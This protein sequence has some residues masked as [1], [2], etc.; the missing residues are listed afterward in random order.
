MKYPLESRPNELV[1]PVREASSHRDNWFSRY[2]TLFDI[3]WTTEAALIQ[4]FINSSRTGSGAHSSLL[5]LDDTNQLLI[6]RMR[7][8]DA[9][10]GSQKMEAVVKD[11]IAVI[12]LTPCFGRNCR[13]SEGPI[14]QS[15][16]SVGIT[17]FVYHKFVLGYR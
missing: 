17:Q 1:I 9:I 3:A 5:T 2:W 4:L 12:L 13:C 10:F 7:V 8:L 15:D 11:S 14:A 6:T 16:Y